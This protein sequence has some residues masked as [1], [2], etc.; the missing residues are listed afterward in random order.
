MLHWDDKH[1]TFTQMI[2]KLILQFKKYK[3]EVMKTVMG[4]Q[5]TV[6]GN[7][8]SDTVITIW[9]QVGIRLIGRIPSEGIELSDHY[10]LLLKPT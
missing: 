4:M 2:L 9:C 10:A 1:L 8:V 5:N 3:L 6:T 7:I